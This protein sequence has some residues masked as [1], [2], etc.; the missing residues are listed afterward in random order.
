MPQ[1]SVIIPVYNA[2]R[3]LRQC[4]D[5]ILAQTLKDIEVICVDDGSEDATADIL[6]EYSAKDLRVRVLRQEKAGAGAARNL[7]LDRAVGDYLLFCDGD[8]WLDQ[9]MVRA[10]HR[11][12]CAKAADIAVSGVRYFD[13]MQQA[14][15][16]VRP[17]PRKVLDLAQ[18][19]APEDLGDELFSSLRIQTWNKLFRR[20]FV[21]A[22]SLRFQEQPRVNDL[23]FV[24]SAVTLAERIVA[25][26]GT[27][28]HYRKNQGGN[29]SSKINQFPDMSAMAWLRVRENL[30]AHGI[31]EKFRRPFEMAAS[32]ALV[33]VMVSVTDIAVARDFYRRIRDELIPK[34]GLQ[35]VSS[36]PAARVFFAEEDP[37]AFYMEAL[38]TARARHAALHAKVEAWKAHPLAM[39]IGKLR[40]HRP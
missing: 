18:P 13:Q 29:L 30:T 3:Y 21:R 8:D 22:Q 31:F 28:Y 14:D 2:E 9:D 7:C 20:E 4:L 17:L 12:A 1:V 37:L 15:F 16:K 39:L 5:S 27:Y 38:S 34:L 24:A 33:E 23:A 32:Q 19:F 11:A 35:E 25:I 26:P 36:V 10:L 40:G 6:A